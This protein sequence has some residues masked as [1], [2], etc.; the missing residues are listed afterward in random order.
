MEPA[1]RIELFAIL[2][3]DSDETVRE[4]AAQG[5]H[6][7]PLS[8]IVE[9]LARPGAAAE[10]FAYCAAELPRQPSVADARQK[11]NLPD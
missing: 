4:M 9:A 8:A 7:Q 1:D 10:M 2:A 5:L 11:S 6:N 3:A